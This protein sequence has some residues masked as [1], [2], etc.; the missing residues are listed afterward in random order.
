MATN[1]CNVCNLQGK[2][3]APTEWCTHCEEA[4][5]SKCSLQHQ[6]Q[7]ATRD[8]NTISYVDYCKLPP[9]ILSNQPMCK[10]HSEKFRYYCRSHDCPLCTKCLSKSH[11][12][13]DDTPDIEKVIDNVKSSAVFEDIY[14]DLKATHQRLLNALNDRKENLSSLQKKKEEIQLQV[15]DKTHQLIEKLKRLENKTLADL[16]SVIHEY[17]N[18]IK[19]TTKKLESEETKLQDKIRQKQLILKYASNLQIFIEIKQTEKEVQDSESTL[20]NLY[21][22]G[23]MNDIDI[24]IEETNTLE[25]TIDEIK[26][27]GENK[28]FR[29]KKTTPIDK[30]DQASAQMTI[31]TFFPNHLTLRQELIL[32][33]GEYNGCY[34][35]PKGIMV[36]PNYKNKK[37]YILNS[38]SFKKSSVKFE[39]TVYDVALINENRVAVSHSYKS[40][41]SIIEIKKSRVI[42]TLN[43]NDCP[44]G[45]THRDDFLFFCV[46]S[47][48]IMKINVKT[49]SIDKVYDDKSVT[50][51]SHVDIY[52]NRL[53]YTCPQNKK[54]TVLD[55]NNQLI[56]TIEDERILSNPWDISLDHHQ[57]IFVCN[58]KKDNLIVISRDGNKVE[59]L[60]SK[61]DLH[62]PTAV[63]YDRDNKEVL[64]V[65]GNCVA[66]IFFV[67]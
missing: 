63:H 20:Q 56:F 17:E 58:N 35:L 9:I 40:K 54:L 18:E 47:K 52:G 8:H 39:D 60:F 43:T 11:Q 12:K 37:V 51:D 2:Q 65:D 27:L 57:N 46:F 29:K 13:C 59:V 4:L 16:D 30:E 28:V 66:R 31:E 44:W 62:C 15:K 33:K 34:I 22:E 53:C 42:K 67:Y 21:R 64:V 41:I 23:A 10:D 7:K 50:V 45:I 48:G 5:C 19:A 25:D 6:V 55:S 14:K 26:S 36:F 3:N 32:T 61:D 24:E 1:N 38:N 49:E